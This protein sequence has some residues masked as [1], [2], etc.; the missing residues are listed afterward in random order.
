MGLLDDAMAQVAQTL[1]G[2]FVDNSLTVRRG[3]GTYDFTGGPSGSGSYTDYTVK[4]APPE[5]VFQREI[6]KGNFKSGDIRVLVPTA[7]IPEAMGAFNISTDRIIFSGETREWQ[8]V[9]TSEINS[10]DA[11]AAI[12]LYL[13]K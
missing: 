6:D 8:I 13:R 11:V 4:A 9:E 3:T 1:V 7:N 12:V 5:S 10:G 2:V